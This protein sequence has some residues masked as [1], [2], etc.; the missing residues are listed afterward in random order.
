MNDD[1][2]LFEDDPK[3]SLNHVIKNAIKALFRLFLSLI[4][5][6][7]IKVKESTYQRRLATCKSCDFLYNENRCS[8][9]GCYIK[10]KCSLT[11]EECPEGYW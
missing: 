6:K 2:D 1:L 3:P 9:C 11:T 8:K 5:F 10:A 7:R 4:T